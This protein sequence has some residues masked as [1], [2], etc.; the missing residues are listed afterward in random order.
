MG[1][2][3][4]NRTNNF[5]PDRWFDEKDFL[6]A[7]KKGESLVYGR[8][9]NGCLEVDLERSESTTESETN[10]TTNK[11]T[12][13]NTSK[14]SPFHLKVGGELI[15]TIPPGEIYILFVDRLKKVKQSKVEIVSLNKKKDTWTIDFSSPKSTEITIQKREKPIKRRKNTLNLLQRSS[16]EKLAVIKKIKEQIQSQDE[17]LKQQ[18]SQLEQL[19]QRK[20]DMSEQDNLKDDSLDNITSQEQAI[21]STAITRVLFPEIVTE[22]A[23]LE[24]SIDD[25]ESS[26]EQKESF[27]FL[28][29]LETAISLTLWQTLLGTPLFPPPHLSPKKILRATQGYKLLKERERINNSRSSFSQEQAKTVLGER[30]FSLLS[31]HFEKLELLLSMPNGK[32]ELV[33]LL[34]KLIPKI[35]DQEM[36]RKIIEIME[37][38]GNYEEYLYYIIFTLL[39]QMEMATNTSTDEHIPPSLERE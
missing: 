7:G 36:A 30:L 16:Q 1:K 24:K 19:S 18:Q 26:A 15:A 31:K 10:Q 27:N 11:L 5:E 17:L 23:V 2:K 25:K 34:K 12:L 3:N 33:E 9:K 22:I 37:S 21:I 28:S 13:R 32:K 39:E 8:N 38:L 4:S 6:E 20:A 35:G 29:F 14:A